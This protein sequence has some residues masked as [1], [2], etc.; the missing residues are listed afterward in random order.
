MQREEVKVAWCYSH[1]YI[2]TTV[3]EN[4]SRSKYFNTRYSTKHEKSSV[5]FFVDDFAVTYK[6]RIMNWNQIRFIWFKLF[7]E[8]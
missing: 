7:T 8:N 4:A 1:I 3:T 5:H 6:P 2:Q